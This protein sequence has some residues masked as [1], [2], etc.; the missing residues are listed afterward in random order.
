MPA[1]LDTLYVLLFAAALPLFD[2]LVS[3]PAFQRRWQADP[4]RARRRLW[5][6][7]IPHA[8]AVVAAGAVVWLYYDRSWESF[9]FSIPEGWQLWTSIGL[10][11]L[12]V[13]YLVPSAASVARNAEVRAS[14]RQQ[15]EGLTA[16]V[17]PHT[18]T[19]MYWFAGVSL[20]AGF[21]EEFL[22][23]GYFIWVLSP[24][25]GWWGAAA[26]SLLIFASGHAYQ[27]RSGVIRTGVAG[28]IFTLVV[29]I[30]DSLWPAIVLHFLLD[31]GM[32]IIAW[33]ALRE[34]QSTAG[35]AG[36]EKQTA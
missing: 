6:E 28:L 8:W 29:G 36:M 27:G 1:L 15:A 9:G 32:G 30:L 24:W 2:Y 21:C 16:A 35:E 5:A 10:I 25:L 23:R 18:R 17:L 33:L 12:L 20:T 14:V 13:A 31:L 3:W 4:A 11:L 22:F 19:D 26:L 34:G 7:V